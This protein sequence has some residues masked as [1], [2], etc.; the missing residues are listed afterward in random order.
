MP[1]KL[2]KRCR[3]QLKATNDFYR[4][5][6]I[7]VMLALRR[8]SR[9]EEFLTLVDFAHKRTLEKLEAQATLDR[10]RAA[11]PGVLSEA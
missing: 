9:Q 1:H 7:H 2:D 8:S 10:L 11:L 3:P 5:S 4:G 6:D